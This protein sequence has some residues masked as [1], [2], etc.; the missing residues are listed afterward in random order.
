[1]GGDYDLEGNLPAVLR[2]QNTGERMRSFSYS[3]AGT[4][5][6]GGDGGGDAWGTVGP[7]AQLPSGLREASYTTG[8]GGGGS[9]YTPIISTGPGGVITQY[10]PTAAGGWASMG[11][12]N[13]ANAI[14]YNN[15]DLRTAHDF[16]SYD[17]PLLRSGANDHFAVANI[18][19]RQASYD[20]PLPVVET[21]GTAR[22]LPPGYTD[23]KPQTPVSDPRYVQ[24]HSDWDEGADSGPSARQRN[25]QD[26]PNGFRAG[27]PKLYGDQLSPEQQAQEARL[28]RPMTQEEFNNQPVTGEPPPGEVRQGPGGVPV[29]YSEQGKWVPIAPQQ[30][31]EGALPW[32]VA[33]PS[34]VQQ[35]SV[36]YLTGKQSLV[37]FIGGPDAYDAPEVFRPSK[38]KADLRQQAAQLL[39]NPGN[40]ANR[41]IIDAVMLGSQPYGVGAT[42]GRINELDINNVFSRE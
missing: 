23:L 10:A 21:S 5:F 6:G 40:P 28:N 15:G 3:P 41:G 36:P 11:N 16:G 8:S 19:P 9:S 12:V 26:D 14:P 20:S 25:A 18:H 34:N 2:G 13:G 39:T 4:A 29:Q 27:N 24:P 37:D 38:K 35:S 7:P 17:T 33:P 42:R 31:G 30:F 32:A 22:L 1:M